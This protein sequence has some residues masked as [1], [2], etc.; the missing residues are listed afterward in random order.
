MNK[1]IKI[2]AILNVIK[3]ALSVLFPLITYPYALRVLGAE[4]IGK[5]SY[6]SSIISYFA[7]LAMLGTSTYG[8]REGA[9]RKNNK[10][11]F[12]MFV[13]EIFTINLISTIIAYILLFIFTATIPK[14]GDYKK[15]I[16][17]QSVSIIF[18]TIGLEWINIVF[19]DFLIITVRS[20]FTHVLTMV[21]LF[22]FVKT[23]NDYY[24]YALLTV[25]ANGIVSISNWFYIK[26]YVSVHITK[27]INIK[28][29]IKPLMYLFSNLIAISVYVNFD[30]T[31]LGWMK[32]DTDVGYYAVSV[33]IYTIIKN[34]LAAAYAV[35]I[36]RLSR[37]IG[38]HDYKSY[39]HLYSKVCSCLTLILVPAGIGMISVAREIMFF[40]GGVKYLDATIALQ[41]LSISLIFSIYG[42]LITAVLNVTIG[43]EKDNLQA[44]IIS[45][46]INC[47]L[48]IFFINYFSYAGAAFT[49]TISELFVFVFCL[50][51]I[52]N[53]ELYIK[54][55]DVI[56]NLV[57]A[58]GGA[59]LIIVISIIVK[60][61]VLSYIIRLLLII[62][63]SVI[64]YI[65]Y[66]LIRKNKLF[67]E[68][69][70]NSIKR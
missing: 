38:E 28:N 46:F 18:T 37:Y 6:G 10:E 62:I 65:F 45:A 11:H 32:N 31:M 22:L 57:D 52:P 64:M 9:K 48:N 16:Y 69:L 13:N 67:I 4:G 55:Q 27:E 41:I 19:E 33:K 40:M 8:V 35:A 29:H 43:R 34:M 2:N 20:I 17:L 30:T 23:P 1:N 61:I 66:L 56:T 68:L 39:K 70:N 44:T 7:L 24:I 3:Q 15:L 51:R 53:K 49:T 14:L 50:V 47:I 21:C 25:L 5:V 58:I 12:Q 36:P 59:I 60:K 26:K 54:K 63:L 42:G